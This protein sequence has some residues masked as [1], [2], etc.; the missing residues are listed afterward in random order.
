MHIEHRKVTQVHLNSMDVEKA[1]AE[2]AYE[3]L[4]I[5][6][7]TEPPPDIIFKPDNSGI[8]RAIVTYLHPEDK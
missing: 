8:P 6:L 7:R 2:Y 1:I 5:Q 3:L 4:D